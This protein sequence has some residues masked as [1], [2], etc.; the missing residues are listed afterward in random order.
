MPLKCIKVVG[1]LSAAL[2]RGSV[3]LAGHTVVMARF[4]KMHREGPLSAMML[5]FAGGWLLVCN[6]MSTLAL[7]TLKGERPALQGYLVT[8]C[9]I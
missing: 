5:K 9:L 8:G 7:R 2:F 4:L 1:L 3:Q 6:Q